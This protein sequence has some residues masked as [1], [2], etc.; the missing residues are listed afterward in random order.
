PCGS[1]RRRLRTGGESRSAKHRDPRT[2]SARCWRAPIRPFRR[3]HLRRR[4]RHVRHAAARQTRGTGL[5]PGTYSP[6]SDAPPRALFQLPGR[7]RKRPT[8][9]DSPLN[10][11]IQRSLSAVALRWPR[12]LQL[13]GK[14]MRRILAI[15]FVVLT[16]VLAQSGAFAAE[17]RVTD[18]QAQP[19]DPQR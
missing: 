5:R 14:S 16:S 17:G 9:A 8:E 18:L 11:N 3:R 19:L 13:A 2:W 12:V 7:V 1:V 10:E 4:Q 6:V 15:G